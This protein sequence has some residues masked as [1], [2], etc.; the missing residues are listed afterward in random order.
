MSDPKSS[1]SDS[2]IERACFEERKLK[3]YNLI[4]I[5]TD[6]LYEA[7]VDGNEEATKR[8][9][10]MADQVIQAAGDKDL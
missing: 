4:I 1:P 5:G 6:L 2:R 9:E 10:C 3:A 8:L 7:A